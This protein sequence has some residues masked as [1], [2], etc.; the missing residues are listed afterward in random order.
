[1][2][3]TI[4]GFAT[5][6][7]DLR[8]KL[9][10]NSDELRNNPE[11]LMN[12]LGKAV[13]GLIEAAAELPKSRRHEV[14]ILLEDLRRWLDVEEYAKHCDKSDKEKFASSVRSGIAKTGVVFGDKLKALSLDLAV[15][16]PDTSAEPAVVT[17][18]VE[19]TPTAP[20][21]NA[22]K[23]DA[24]I[25]TN[26]TPAEPVPMPYETDPENW[27]GWTRTKVAKG[28]FPDIK[29]NQGWTDFANARRSEGKM[30]N[31]PTSKYRAV[32]IHRSVFTLCGVPFPHSAK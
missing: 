20:V 17:A 15:W 23:A 3:I 1:M 26:P 8:D 9:C 11:G 12:D 32:T 13:R 16:M 7:N 2:T 21:G 24:A 5:A 31:H 4:G 27:T 18:T 29:S 19:T 14:R 10:L 28:Y 6:L 30:F 25:D 22:A